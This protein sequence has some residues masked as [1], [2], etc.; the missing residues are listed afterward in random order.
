MN[1][2]EISNWKT[3]YTLNLFKYLRK[4]VYNDVIDFC[5]FFY[6]SSGPF[7]ICSLNAGAPFKICSIKNTLSPRKGRSSSIFFLFT[8]DVLLKKKVFYFIKS[9]RKFV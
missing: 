1:Q 3:F 8:K 4:I 6:I 2:N 9:S 5:D 7:C